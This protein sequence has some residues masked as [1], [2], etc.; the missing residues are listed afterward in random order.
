M[1]KMVR[2]ANVTDLARYPFYPLRYYILTENPETEKTGMYKTHRT[3]EAA[4]RLGQFTEFRI[5]DLIENKISRPYSIEKDGKS[6]LIKWRRNY[7]DSDYGLDDAMIWEA[8]DE[9]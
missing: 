7:F 9:E 2:K 8:P 1:V 4:F 5:V 6:F 3:T